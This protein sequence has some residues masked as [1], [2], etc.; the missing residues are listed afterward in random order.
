MNA[1]KTNGAHQYP[2]NYDHT[3]YVCNVCNDSGIAPVYGPGDSVRTTR[4]ACGTPPPA[5]C[6]KP[7]PNLSGEALRRAMA[8]HLRALEDAAWLEAHAH[9]L[10]NLADAE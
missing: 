1:N 9:E 5:W 8:E 6:G 2:A 4:F 10:A 3:V 7:H